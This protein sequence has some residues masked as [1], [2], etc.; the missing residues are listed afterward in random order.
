MLDYLIAKQLIVR[1]FGKN[2]DY[3]TIWQRAV[4][5]SKTR[6][7][8]TPDEV[9]L[10]ECIPVFAL[11]TSA[12]HSRNVITDPDNIPIIQTDRAGG[13]TYH[14]PGQL[15]FG[16]NL[17][18]DRLN[19]KPE[20]LKF[21]LY[22]ITAQL[23]KS[24]MIDITFNCDHQNEP[25][26]GLFVDSGKIGFVEVSLYCNRCYHGLSFNI[27]MDL[28]PFSKIAHCGFENLNITHLK[29]HI[30]K[31][32]WQEIKSKLVEYFAKHLRYSML[33]WEKNSKFF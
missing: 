11:G 27:D 25:V 26:F 3:Q 12:K 23:L 17:D 2:C 20:I 22:S 33:F 6:D 14:G 21:I 8:N 7:T 30:L 24:Y 10:Y 29:D 9:W 13:P 31:I 15:M 18:L 16:V 19:I 32:D 28:T 5:F 1:D 4:D